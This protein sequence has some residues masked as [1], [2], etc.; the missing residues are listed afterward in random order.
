ME[1][2]YKEAKMKGLHCCGSHFWNL[3]RNP[4]YCEKIY[5][6]AYKEEESRHVHGL[7]EPIISEALFYEVQQLLDGKKKTY[8]TQVG[9]KEILQLRGYLLCPRCGKLLTGSGSRGRNG[10]YYYYHCHSS[11]GTRFRAIPSTASF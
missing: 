3:L 4:V 8:R 5:F 7:H 2:L 11:C 9:G 1:Q 10:L 6:S